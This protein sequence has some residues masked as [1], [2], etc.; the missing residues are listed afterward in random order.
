LGID[1]DDY[2]EWT[3]LDKKRALMNSIR[4]LAD[5]RKL[6]DELW[7]DTLESSGGRRKRDLTTLS[8]FAYGSIF[9]LE[10]FHLIP[11]KIFF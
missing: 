7:G 1:L 4:R 6:E 11:L 5:G 3:A 10:K 9:L 8:P 2:G